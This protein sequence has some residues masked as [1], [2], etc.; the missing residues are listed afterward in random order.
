[1]DKTRYLGSKEACKI[2]GV[3]Y[4]TLY[5]WEKNNTIEAIRT[6]GG[7]RLYN[8]DKYI[9]EHI[10]VQNKN[11]NKKNICY[12]RV[13]TYGQKDD[14]KR[15]I[16]YMKEKYPNYIIIKDIGSG[17]N[18]KRKGLKKIIDLAVDGKINNLVIAYKDRLCRFGYEIFEYL[19]HEHSMGSITILNNIKLSPNEEL[20]RDL[21]SIINI[22]SSRIN[23]LRKYKT[24]IQKL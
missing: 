3:H 19:I 6:P 1:M 21:V 12:C 5:N 17:L 11:E 20:T 8:I 24:E 7:K 22:F 9:K 10:N 16:E 13:S 18:F 23:G 14:L 4:K 15:Q 2:L